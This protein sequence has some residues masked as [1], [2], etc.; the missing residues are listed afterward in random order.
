MSTSRAASWT[1]GQRL[2]IAGYVLGIVGLAVLGLEQARQRDWLWALLA[3]ATLVV[4]AR[5]LVGEVRRGSAS[6][7]A[8]EQRR[9]Q[10]VESARAAMTPAHL[11]ALAQEHHLDVGTSTGRIELIKVVRRAD[12]RL[13]LVDAKTLVDGLER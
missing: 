2:E 13:T 11:S 3:A 7:R 10:G 5:A 9:R 6:G 1:W 12:R 8:A 4:L